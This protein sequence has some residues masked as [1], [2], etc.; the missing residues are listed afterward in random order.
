MTLYIIQSKKTESKF[1]L[2]ISEREEERVLEHNRGQTK[3]TA[4]HSPWS[5]IYTKIF[6]T[7]SEAI[8]REKHL[9]SIEGYK[10]RKMIIEKHRMW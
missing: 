4:M 10:E 7:R 6:K 1:Y 2:G 3:T 9:K 8:R 5:V